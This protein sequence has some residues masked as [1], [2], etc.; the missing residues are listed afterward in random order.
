MP[1]R[2][3]D[4]PGRTSYHKHYA[5][6]PVDLTAPG[7]THAA[8]DG[9]TACGALVGLEEDGWIPVPDRGPVTCGRCR[10]ACGLPPVPSEERTA[11]PS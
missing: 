1:Q 4:F 10:F 2:L 9:R 8:R 3:A 7:N 6:T 5:G 11:L